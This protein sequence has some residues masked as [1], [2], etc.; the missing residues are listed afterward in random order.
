MA[1]PEEVNEIVI[2]QL[3]AIYRPQKDPMEYPEDFA[4]MT[5]L[6]VEVLTD[7]HPAILRVG[8]EILRREWAF[9]SWPVPAKVREFMCEAER[10]G[11][12]DEPKIPYY[13]PPPMTGPA[14]PSEWMKRWKEIFMNGEIRKWTAEQALHY[15]KSGERPGGEIPE[16][17]KADLAKAQDDPAVQKAWRETYHVRAIAEIVGGKPKTEWTPDEFKAISRRQAELRQELGLC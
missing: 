2:K 4:R 7:F 3:T 16:S 9:T 14:V 8:M 13:R 1:T 5:A 15:C 12:K 17:I 6:Y 11:R 10:L